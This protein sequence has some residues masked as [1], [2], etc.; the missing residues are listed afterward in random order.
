MPGLVPGTPVFFLVHQQDMDG[1]D[2][3]DEPGDDDA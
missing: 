2:E 3:P 1:R